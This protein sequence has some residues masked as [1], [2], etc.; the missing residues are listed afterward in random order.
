[1][2]QG[3]GIGFPVLAVKLVHCN[4]QIHPIVEAAPGHCEAILIGARHVKTLDAACL[5]EAMF[6][7]ARIERVLA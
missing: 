5:A 1:M 7:A 2:R 3:A 4:V 6:C